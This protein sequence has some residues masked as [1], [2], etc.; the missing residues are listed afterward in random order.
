M[1]QTLL[2]ALFLWAE[3]I[4]TPAPVVTP[5]EQE[6]IAATNAARVVHGVKPL[7]PDA[8]MMAHARQYTIRMSRIGMRHS[9]CQWAENIATGQATIASV[10]TTWLNSSRHRAN[11]LNARHSK[12]GICGYTINGRTW[13]IQVFK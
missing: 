1:I 4:A 6:M 7:E 2:I 13:W 9:G 10:I 12:I 11:M 8:A 5:F 3:T